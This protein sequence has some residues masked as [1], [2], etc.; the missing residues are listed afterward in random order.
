M[1]FYF[2]KRGTFNIDYYKTT[3]EN[4]VI[5]D[6]E[7]QGS[8][9]FYNLDGESIAHSLQFDL[10]YEILNRFDIQLAYKLNNVKKTF[11]MKKS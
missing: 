2:R 11:E 9:T 5:V 10:T 7:D 8:L 3:F 6:I 1:F 4:Q